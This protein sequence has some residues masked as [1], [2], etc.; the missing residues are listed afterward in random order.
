MPSAGN[1]RRRFFPLLMAAGLAAITGPVKAASGPAD[2]SPSFEKDVRPIILANCTGCHNPRKKKGDLDLSQFQ[3]SEKAAADEETWMDVADRLGK[4]D[5]PPRKAKKRP[6]DDER[7]TILKWIENH[8]APVDAKCQTIE[9]DKNVKSYRGYV[10]SRR[11]TRAEYGNTIRDLMGI[12]LRVEDMLPADGSGGEG[13]D[14]EGDALFVSAISL[15]KYLQAAD[16]V[17]RTVLPDAGAPRTPEA[18]AAHDRLFA[19]TETEDS[20][21]QNDNCK[22]QIED[23]LQFAFC[24][25]HFAICYASGP[26]SLPIVV[27][28]QKPTAPP[29]N[30][31]RGIIAA[32][33]RRAFRRP[34][35]TAEI[36]RLMSL[37]DRQQQHGQPFD[38]SLRY[39]LKAVLISPNFLFL[40]EPDPAEGGVYRLGDY[41]IASRLSYF[42]WSSMPDEE[43]F[44]L[45][46][47]GQL[48]D[49]DVLRRQVRRMLKD[50]R[51]IAL[52]QNLAI[53]WL[54][55]TALGGANR[56]DSTRFPDFNESL[57]EAERQE[58]ILFFNS[59]IHEDHSLVDLLD[60]NYTFVNEKLAAIYGIPGI[61]GDEMRRVQ[62]S[63]RNRGGVLG[64]AAMLTAT[65][66]PLRTSPVLR[67]KW[68]LEQLLGERVPPP[69]PTAGQLPPDD[70]QADGLSF[71]H[72]L[73]LHRANPE[74]ASCHA[75]MDPLGFGLENFDAI[76]RWRTRQADAPID[77]TGV[78]PNGKKF[79]GPRGLKDVL[80]GRKAQFLHNFSRKLLGYALGRGL[81]RFDECVIDNGVKALEADGD[82]PAALIERIVLSAPFQYRFA[83]K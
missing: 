31:A 43:L 1:I 81:N 13:F 55:I 22:L 66:Y 71:R 52:A 8:V 12:D 49:N 38:A 15:E 42:L 50:P 19:A 54:G 78:L 80:L 83:K 16:L 47:K 60:A 24:N 73:E 70:H 58:V 32:F 56:P 9:T 63:D 37:F 21:L 28:D 25:C 67:G 59:I 51:S 46:A 72:R 27:D 5:M 4:K 48:H 75:R 30:S 7:K 35:E 44:S 3:T 18:Q 10:M 65:S 6:N 82:K 64:M 17:M 76:G 53:Q 14:T 41:Q 69:P 26:M 61:Q 39:A 11:L 77:A 36:D 33:A 23:W 45:A 74:C 79:D 62:L 68:V 57:I 29:R 20:K 2:F 40:V 34:V